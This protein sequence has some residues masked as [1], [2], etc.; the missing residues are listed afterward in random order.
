MYIHVYIYTYIHVH[1]SYTIS[2]A[3]KFGPAASSSICSQGKRGGCKATWKRGVKLPWREAGSP[4][5][6]IDIEDSDQ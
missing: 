3:S 4:H 6:Q 5:H 2:A 1:I